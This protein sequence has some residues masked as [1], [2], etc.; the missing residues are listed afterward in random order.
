M[1]TR[2]KTLFLMLLLL[3]GSLPLMAQETTKVQKLVI[4][5]ND[6]TEVSFL[7]SEEPKITFRHNYSDNMVIS[8]TTKEIEVSAFELDK[9]VTVSVEESGIESIHANN[10]TSFKWEGDALMIEVTSGSSSIT[11]YGM[12]GKNYFSK[13]LTKGRHALSLSK[14]PKGAYVINIDGETIKFWNR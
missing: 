11:V 4:T 2:L 13:Q 8:T 5:K 7:L 1:K 6:K 10:N 3:S 12:D 9:M 14:L